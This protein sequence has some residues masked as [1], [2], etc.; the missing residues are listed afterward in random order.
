MNNQSVLTILPPPK[1]QLAA[2][3]RLL[4]ITDG[5]SE[6]DTKYNGFRARISNL[7]LKHHLNIQSIK[8]SFVTD[9]G[10]LSS[11]SRH[12]IVSHCKNEAIELYFKINK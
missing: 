7:K 11:Y 2:V 8:E 3:L 5:L 9:L 10:K 12:F 1:N 4:V 6:R